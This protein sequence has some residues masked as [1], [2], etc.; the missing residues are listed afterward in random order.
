MLAYVYFEE[1][2]GGRAAA[3]LLPATIFR[4]NFLKRFSTD[5]DRTKPERTTATEFGVHV[6]CRLT[7]ASTSD[8]NRVQPRSCVMLRCPE[9]RGRSRY[10]RCN[11]ME[12]ALSNGDVAA[13]LALVAFFAVVVMV[14]LMSGNGNGAR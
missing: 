1:E 2:L 10:G 5:W 6:I 13:I 12:T 14:R 3:K 11:R 4:T 7:E 9:R 8:P